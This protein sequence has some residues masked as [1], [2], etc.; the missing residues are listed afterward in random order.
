M[1]K[2]AAGKLIRETLETPFDRERYARFTRN[3]F[4]SYEPKT[5]NLSGNNVRDSFEDYIQSYERLLPRPA[6]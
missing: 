5:F 3:L 2:Q 4:K 6:P 1:D